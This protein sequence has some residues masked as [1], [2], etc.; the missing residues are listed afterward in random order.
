MTSQSGWQTF[1]IHTYCAIYHEVK[2]I[3][4]R[5]K[6]MKFGQLVE[7]DMRKSFLETS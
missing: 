6:T 4:D 1:V 3:I 7:Y 5:L 2:I